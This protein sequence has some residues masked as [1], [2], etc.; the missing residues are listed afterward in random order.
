MGL[1]ITQCNCCLC[2][3]LDGS[4]THDST[5]RNFNHTGVAS[6]RL[7][8]RQSQVTHPREQGR[9]VVVLVQG[10]SRDHSKRRDVVTKEGKTTRRETRQAWHSCTQGTNSIAMGK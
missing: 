7:G 5:S 2:F 6:A 9:V 4:A 10:G 1:H 8:Y 3:C